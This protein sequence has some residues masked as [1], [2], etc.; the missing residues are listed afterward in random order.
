MTWKFSIGSLLGATAVIAAVACLIA[1]RAK[2]E[3]VRQETVENKAEIQ[4]LRMLAGEL[5]IEDRTRAAAMF[6]ESIGEG[7][8]WLFFIPSNKAIEIRIKLDEVSDHS[9]PYDPGSFLAATLT[10]EGENQTTHID[11]SLLDP[12]QS[13]LVIA[14]EEATKS[15]AFEGFDKRWFKNMFESRTV[16]LD[17][18]QHVLIAYVQFYP[19]TQMTFNSDLDTNGIAVW[20]C[21]RPQEEPTGSLD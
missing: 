2:F 7:D 6:K 13:K 16:A 12:P 19:E 4:R 3:E 21:V 1:S 20:A 18:G 9:S 5:N 11:V 10:A 14:S 15:F 8:R 17:N